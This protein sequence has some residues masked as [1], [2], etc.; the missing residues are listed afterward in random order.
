MEGMYDDALDW[1]ERA[2]S[3]GNEN[4]PWF[5]ANPLWEPLREDPRFRAL[6]RRIEEGREDAGHLA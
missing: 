6:M 5:E 4:R 1:L 2:I 3:L